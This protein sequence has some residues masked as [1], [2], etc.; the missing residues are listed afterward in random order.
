MNDEEQENDHGEEDEEEKAEAGAAGGGDGGRRK[1]LRMSLLRK[2]EEAGPRWQRSSRQRE[3]ARG[4]G[5]SK[6]I[7]GSIV[8]PRQLAPRG[9]DF[10]QRLLTGSSN[11]S[12][13]TLK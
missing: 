4:Q 5:G 1:E 11:F 7:G 10:R 13:T 12:K 8:F 9:D 2:V 3:A 6:E